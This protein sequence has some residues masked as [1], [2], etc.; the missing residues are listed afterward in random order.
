MHIV[1]ELHT[2]MRLPSRE[3]GND[4][5]QAQFL[6]TEK[7]MEEPRDAATKLQVW[8]I[9]PLELLPQTLGLSS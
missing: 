7:H 6:G 2:E 1:L 3:E 9:C 8:Y 5:V 4:S